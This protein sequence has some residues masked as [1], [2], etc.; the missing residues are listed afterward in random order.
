MA[1]CRPAR[2]LY[3]RG[4][5]ITG[6]LPRFPGPETETEISGKD[7]RKKG[8]LSVGAVRQDS[9]LRPAR[10][11]NVPRSPM[12]SKYF[13]FRNCLRI[14]YNT[15]LAV[16]LSACNGG[17]GCNSDSASSIPSFSTNR[18]TFP[19]QGSTIASLPSI[20][21][22][23][24]LDIAFI[25]ITLTRVSD[26][27]VWNGS[28][29]SP[30]GSTYFSNL[31]LV[32]G[33]NGEGDFNTTCPMPAGS[34]PDTGLLDG[35][36]L[37]DMSIP[38]T[39]LP[40]VHAYYGF[41]VGSTPLP[42]AT[43]PFAWGY[44]GNGAVGAG[45][46]PNANAATKVLTTGA[47]A[48]KIVVSV[49][50]GAEHTLA[51]GSDGR[52]YAW[53]RNDRGQLG[54]GF[55]DQDHQIPDTNNRDVPTLVPMDPS[56]LPIVG[57]G[58]GDY[59]SL[60]VTLD[61]RVLT[62]GDNTSGQLAR[63]LGEPTF[64]NGPSSA[65]VTE[66]IVQSPDFLPVES[67]FVNRL[68]SIVSG[69]SNFSVVR[70]A[71]GKVFAWGA[72][73]NGQLGDGTT[74]PR[75]NPV[76]VTGLT[77]KT[78]VQL[79]SGSFH[80]LVRTAN[81]EVYAWGAGA[82]GLLGNGSNANSSAAVRTGL[83]GAMAGR[84]ISTIS[85][86][87]SHS[88]ALGTDGAVFVWGSNANH[89]LGDGGVLPISN[90]PL[91]VGGSLTGLRAT[92]V[93]AGWF[94]SLVATSDARLFTW[95]DNIS[96]NLCGAVGIGA[97]ATVPTAAPAGNAI[98]PYNIPALLSTGWDHA[99]LLTVSGPGPVPELLVQARGAQLVSGTEF[100]VGTN[101]LGTSNTV[102][103]T[104]TNRGS[105]DLVNLVLRLTGSAF[106]AS[107]LTTTHL[108]PGQSLTFNVTYNATSLG[109]SIGT[110]ELESND[111]LNGLFRLNLTGNGAGLGAVDTSFANPN[112]VGDVYALAVQTDRSVVAGGAFSSA[113]GSP[114]SNLARFLPTGA[115]DPAFNPN[116]NGP[117]NCVA[118][119]PDGAL[120]IA[121]NF[122][123]VGA[124]PRNRLARI[125]ANGTL[126]AAFN[127]NVLDGVVNALHVNP[128]GSIYVGGS[129]SRIGPASPSFLVRL[130][131][132]GAVEST[133]N[134]ALSSQVRCLA[135]QDDGW[136]VLG[137]SFQ[138]V[139]SANRVRVARVDPDG[140]VDTGFTADTT[141]GNV[142]AV[143]VQTDG[144]I[145]IGGD[146]LAVNGTP[147]NYIAR[148]SST[149]VVD[150]TFTTAVNSVGTAITGLARQANGRTI[151]TGT[152]TQLNGQPR[153]S[154]ARIND[155][156]ATDGF[157][158]VGAGGAVFGA[159][160]V[161]DGHV[162]VGGSFS[163]LGG[164]VRNSLGRLT[165][166]NVSQTFDTLSFPGVVNWVHGAS[167]PE[168]VQ[169]TLEASTNGGSSWVPFGAGVRLP[170]PQIG[171]TWFNAGFP[172]SGL[173]RLRA[174]NRGGLA[175]GSGSL[176]E[177]VGTI[178]TPAQL[179]VTVSGQFLNTGA[180]QDFGAARPGGTNVVTF[181][182]TN[183]G[184]SPLTGLLQTTVSGTGASDFQLFPPASGDSLAGGASTT[185]PVAFKP[186]SSGEHT[187]AL[188][189]ATNSIGSLYSINL[190]GTGGLPI[191]FWRQQYFGNPDNVGPGA[192]VVDG[193]GDGR[194]NLLEYATGTLPNKADK[195]GS[196][197]Q[198]SNGV[199][200][201]FYQRSKQALADV[202]Y[203]VEY[204]NS[205][206]GPWS[207]AGVGDGFVYFDNGIIQMVQCIVP[208]DP[209]PH[210]FARLR[211]TQITQ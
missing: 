53:G 101:V 91:Q 128:N 155:T 134:A 151:V 135:V 200:Y 192:N 56:V 189:F 25:K 9:H 54:L 194:P 14:A 4:A 211:V 90:V 187:A 210:R 162:Y 26:G 133:F 47:L 154:L 180:T 12:K 145:L 173:L 2:K 50:T 188:G 172:S 70:S 99:I 13:T 157:F 44:N 28:A 32:S 43:T 58:A 197:F 176:I 7:V 60:A 130:T 41:R 136:L 37:I 48:G 203:Q 207:S 148:L 141:G 10:G 36:Y 51:L 89:G 16:Y 92:R 174:Y 139:G 117:V 198:A 175:G 66:P 146:F 116:V 169:A 206:A 147:R 121:G 30:P 27:K 46:G 122:T 84:A 204:A 144:R 120:L 107:P 93:A 74:T 153:G 170:A 178:N 95:G 193:E 160:L 179:R 20:Q 125:N 181:T 118:L 39:L 159:M 68:A 108:A 115:L 102:P 103:V 126:D 132:A 42:V 202:T 18:V 119:Q 168:T 191:E 82:G 166:E 55:V 34:D 22:V 177:T 195:D 29:W 40:Y 142:F 77:G 100:I 205:L 98:T 127:P 131:S 129:F 72:N 15:I 1:R 94:S 88:L 64:M 86:S 114:R 21:G 8:D 182:V 75:Y 123:M 78:I 111:I 186:R 196:F 140:I 57:V 163:A 35:F 152:F 83:T 79:S 65:P 71:D 67:P 24:T 62:W 137:G 52:V 73:A 171:W 185:I 61:G 124:T 199:I 110:L 80:S 190:L 138:T 97:N 19:A 17:F 183:L 165:L 156:G 49:A 143:L 76:E 109:A 59:H 38:G 106:S 23:N 87:R 112:I 167:F 208:Q 45:P 3:L 81:G 69:G 184:T 33:F 164:T 105:G 150:N 85:A 31:P 201:F 161:D 6:A 209:S 104:V 113:G 149:G 96:G 11:P 5:L 158:T 63:N